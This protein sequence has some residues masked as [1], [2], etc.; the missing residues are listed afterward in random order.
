MC[1]PGAARGR[2]GTA[3]AD[4]AAADIGEQPGALF[5]RG[6]EPFLRT[7]AATPLASWVEPLANLSGQ[8][9]QPRRHGD[10]E[11]W[12]AALAQLPALP[13][14]RVRLDQACVSV[15]T[16]QPVPPAVRER[17]REALEALHPWRKGPFC[18][19]G[20]E[21]DA[22]WRSD[23]KWARIASAITPL[24]GRRVLDVG[25]GNGYYAYRALGA[26]AGLVLGIDP[27]LRF[28]VQFLA[29]NQ[30]LG[31]ERL[32]VFPLGDDELPRL[33]GAR[34]GNF[35]TVLSM[36]VL[37][38]RRDPDAHL[39]RLRRCLRPGG[40]LVLETLVI[41]DSGRKALV[42]KGRY[43]QMR[44]VH[45]IPSVALLADWLSAAGYEQIRLAGLSRTSTLEQRSTLWMRFQSLADFLDPVDPS[46]T[47]EGY[48][49]PVRALMLA[50]RPS[51][52]SIDRRP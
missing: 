52:S 31:A 41:D 36:G 8:R 4:A 25:C 14:Q 5:Q 49:A 51:A 44:N 48:P 38:H 17:L 33:C 1:S 37:Y 27:T 50:Q 23:W 26:G 15:D 47:V 45:A 3:T 20:V 39:R 11:A 10:L 9:L 2:S 34:E 13:A 29:L 28:V 42:P 43:A 18:L 22:E 35:D 30:L 40:E 19:H 24:A 12:K 16:E 32:A 21:I 6:F 7:L 46:R